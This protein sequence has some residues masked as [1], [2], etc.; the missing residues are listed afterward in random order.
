MKKIMGLLHWATFHE[1]DHS[2]AKKSKGRLAQLSY[3]SYLI[4]SHVGVLVQKEMSRRRLERA[5]AGKSYNEKAQEVQR[6]FKAMLPQMRE[7][8]TM[9]STKQETHQFG[10]QVVKPELRLDSRFL[11]KALIDQEHGFVD[12]EANMSFADLVIFLQ[13]HGFRIPLVPEFLSITVGGAF[14]GVAIESSA[15]IFGVFHEH[16]LQVEVL[17]ADGS[18]KTVSLKQEPA[19]FHMLAGSNGTLG[20]VMR[21][22]LP[23]IPLQSMHPDVNCHPFLDEQRRGAYLAAPQAEP[24]WLEANQPAAALSAA[25]QVKPTEHVH[26]QYHRF[27]ND[28]EALAFFRQRSEQKDCD[29]LEGVMLSPGSTVIISANIVLDVNDVPAGKINSYQTRAVFYSDVNNSNLRDNYVPLPDYYARWHQTVFWNTQNLGSVT[30]LLNLPAFRYVFGRFMGPS[31]IALLGQARS[32]WQQF[33]GV[34]PRLT[35]HLVQDI[36]IPQ[37]NASQYLTFYNY[38]IAQYPVWWCAGRE[39]T[40]EFPLFHVRGRGAYMDFGSFT[41]SGPALKAND[42][43]YFNKRI[44]AVMDDLDGNKGLYS[45]NCP[46]SREVVKQRYNLDQYDAIKQQYDPNGVFQGLLEK[47]FPLLHG[48]SGQ[49][50]HQAKLP[51]SYETYKLWLRCVALSIIGSSVAVCLLPE[52]RSVRLLSGLSVASTI[53]S[54]QCTRLIGRQAST[55]H[56]RDRL[57]AAMSGFGSVGVAALSIVLQSLLKSPLATMVTMLLIAG[58]MTVAV[59]PVK[60]SQV[61]P[62]GPSR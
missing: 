29:F 40:G 3:L 55:L 19:F 58:L 41:G 12:V 24:A 39:T 44:E 54:V 18:L 4:F 60:S 34:K 27:T 16:V 6:A 11:N 30:K 7:G 21:L 51:F 23:L 1:L 57:A 14:V 10:K 47:M 59:R 9:S 49:P 25:R 33:M 37:A 5:Y 56:E 15:H 53:L 38:E 28:A 46:A 42:P 2:Y 62:S 50:P 52:L 31:F 45:D 32:M 8:A 48:A 61:R 35:E 20:R 17:M 13:S 26:L 36:G 43:W 22:R